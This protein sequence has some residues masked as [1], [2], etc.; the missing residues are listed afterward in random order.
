M[1]A[2][3]AWWLIF[4]SKGCG[5]ENV[6]RCKNRDADDM[7]RIK[8]LTQRIG[9]RDATESQDQLLYREK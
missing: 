6:M 8:F 3:V 1:L 7:Y 9:K 5:S 4:F 2:P